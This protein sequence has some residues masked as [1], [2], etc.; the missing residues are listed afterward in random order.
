MVMVLAR[1]NGYE[2]RGRGGTRGREDGKGRERRGGELDERSAGWEGRRGEEGG[3]GRE[4][5]SAFLGNKP[6]ISCDKIEVL[7]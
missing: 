2:D 1:R 5:T 3:K 4:E 6:V 7:R